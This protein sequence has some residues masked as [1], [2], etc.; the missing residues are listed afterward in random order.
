MCLLITKSVI[1]INKYVHLIQACFFKITL[2]DRYFY[3]PR[4]VLRNN[5]PGTSDFLRKSEPSENCIAPAWQ[6][7]NVPLWLSL[8]LFLF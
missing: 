1:N 6:K 7:Y 2:N 3:P 8:S 5:G 4:E